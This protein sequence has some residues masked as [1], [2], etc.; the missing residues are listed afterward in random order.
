MGQWSVVAPVGIAIASGSLL[1]TYGSL[2]GVIVA[3]GS[4]ARQNQ[5]RA[6]AVCPDGKRFEIEFL[7]GSGTANGHGVA[8]DTDGNLYRV[9]F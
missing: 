2:A 8:K 3:G 5:G 7:V 1:G 4:P 6:V 9:L